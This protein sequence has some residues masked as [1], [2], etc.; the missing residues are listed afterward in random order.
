M[1][2]FLLPLILFAGLSAVL[3]A[4]LSNDP[5]VC[6]RRSSASKHPRS[7]CRVSMP[8]TGACPRKRCAARCG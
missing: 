1:K 3:A 5:D 4:S 6:R 7:T 2:R 8:P